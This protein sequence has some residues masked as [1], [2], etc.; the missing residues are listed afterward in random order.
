MFMKIIL[1]HWHTKVFKKLT[2]KRLKGVCNLIMNSSSERTFD[3]LCLLVWARVMRWSICASVHPTYVCQFL[4][5]NVTI[6][7]FMLCLYVCMCVTMCMFII[8]SN[9]LFVLN[10]KRVYYNVIIIFLFLHF[11]SY[12]IFLCLCLRVYLSFVS[13]YLFI[14][15]FLFAFRNFLSVFLHLFLS[16]F[17][18]VFLTFV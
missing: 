15:L 8:W 1:L 13:V 17:I 16:V 7:M 4:S 18:F 6:C 9:V 12:L 11:R 10:Q 2:I 14:I 3:N 5:Y